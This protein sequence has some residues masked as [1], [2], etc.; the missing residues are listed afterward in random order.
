MNYKATQEH[1]ISCALY[2]ARNMEIY[3]ASYKSITV[4]SLARGTQ[5]RTMNNVMKGEITH[6]CFDEGHRKILVADQKGA[7]K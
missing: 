4:W 6:L 2:S 5:T 1:P 3:L 7:I